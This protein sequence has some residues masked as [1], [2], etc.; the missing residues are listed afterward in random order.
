MSTTAWIF[1]P[2]K[3]CD[4]FPLLKLTLSS[5][6]YLRPCAYMLTASILTKREKKISSNNENRI[7]LE[8]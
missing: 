6:H 8:M 2:L 5:I 1:L 4:T 3:C 7:K